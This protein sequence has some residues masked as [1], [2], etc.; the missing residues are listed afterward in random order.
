MTENIQEKSSGNLK[1]KALLIQLTE[2]FGLKQ[3][4]IAKR[5]GVSD[6]YLSSVANGKENPSKQF[7]CALGLLLE[8]VELSNKPKPKPLEEQ[9]EELR[10]EI[11]EIR[12]GKY[13]PPADVQLNEGQRGGETA[14]AGG[15][16]VS[17]GAKPKTVGQ[18]A[19]AVAAALRRAHA[20]KHS[21]K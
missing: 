21:A 10:R 8:L 9:I 4:F 3:Y 12:T 20:K 19:D 14:V 11:W 6:T 18:A 7:E 5:I 1:I 2:S 17:Y 15:E 16:P 13:A